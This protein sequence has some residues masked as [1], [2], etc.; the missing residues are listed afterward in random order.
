[1]VRRIREPLPS[2]PPAFDLSDKAQRDL[3]KSIYFGR[4]SKRVGKAGLEHNDVLQA[5]YMGL[6]VRSRGRSKWDPTRGALSTWMYVAISGIVINEV[7][8]HHSFLRRSGA[9]GRVQDVALWHLS[10]ALDR[11]LDERL[12]LG[13]AG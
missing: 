9:L 6:L 5:I 2:D 11:V 13:Q 1:M 8:K 7:E 10:D 4:F 3:V 12:S